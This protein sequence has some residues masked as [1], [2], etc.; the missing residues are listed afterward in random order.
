MTVIRGVT[1]VDVRTGTL[2]RDVDIAM[3][4][5]RISTIFGPESHVELITAL[6]PGGS[7]PYRGSWRCTPT[8]SAQRILSA[9][10]I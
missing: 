8:C 2:V 4:D 3:A 7:L 5:G 9:T 1:L 6:T 10:S